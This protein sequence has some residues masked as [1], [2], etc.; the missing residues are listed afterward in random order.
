MVENHA[1]ICREC[2]CKHQSLDAARVQ[3][4]DMIVKRGLCC[5]FKRLVGVPMLESRSM[6]LLQGTFTCKLNHR[7]NTMCE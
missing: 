4:P 7:M 2:M 5:C 6:S 1:E 3:Q